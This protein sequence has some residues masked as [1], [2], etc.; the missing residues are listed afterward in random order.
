MNRDDLTEAAFKK[1]DPG[2]GLKEKNPL[3]E[4]S[5]KDLLYEFQERVFQMTNCAKFFFCVSKLMIYSM[6]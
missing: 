5:S 3:L 2:L 1:I 6:I 4:S